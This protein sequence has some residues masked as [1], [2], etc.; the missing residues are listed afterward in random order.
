MTEKE[1]QP[2]LDEERDLSWTEDEPYR[3]RLSKTGAR[4]LRYNRSNIFQNRLQDI[5]TQLLSARLKGE[6][7]TILSFVIWFDPYSHNLQDIDDRLATLPTA[8]RSDLEDYVSFVY[9]FFVPLRVV[10]TK[11]NLHTLK[12]EFS[13]SRRNL[14]IGTQQNHKIIPIT[15]DDT[16]SLENSAAGG[17]DAA[18]SADDSSSNIQF[19]DNFDFS[20][21]LASPPDQTEK[22]LREATEHLGIRSLILELDGQHSLFTEVIDKFYDP[23]SL[24][25][26][27]LRRPVVNR[28]KQDYLLCLIGELAD[29]WREAEKVL[30]KRLKE[31]YGESRR[32][33]RGNRRA[34]EQAMVALRESDGDIKNATHML[35]RM[36]GLDPEIVDDK[37]YRRK[38]E[39]V[40]R[41]KRDLAK[42]KQTS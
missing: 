12:P 2:E 9:R 31:L 30:G 26:V 22:F 1:K 42:G 27:T 20:D 11:E 29:D 32:G 41:V 35:F 37:L 18:A 39:F 8:L 16:G 40:R 36:E 13:A 38:T 25:F 14:L 5:R 34:R 7:A 3:A 23:F 4:H 10:R 21:W 6:T 28:R 33:A 24:N 19:S 15:D 17:S